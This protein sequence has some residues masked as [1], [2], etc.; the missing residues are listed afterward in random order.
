MQPPVLHVPGFCPDPNSVFEELLVYPWKQ[1][2]ITMFGKTHNEPRKVMWFA[3]KGLTYFYA[4][5]ENE[6]LEMTQLLKDIGEYA[7]AVIK[8]QM[9]RDVEFNSVF[10]NF[11]KDGDNYIGW[12][13]DDEPGIASD[14][15]A[16]VS[17]GATRDFQVRRTSDK[18]TWTFPLA[19]GDL[20]IMHSDCQENYK[21]CVPKRKKVKDPRINLTF[22][23]YAH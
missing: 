23:V 14:L 22:R 17:L 3:P 12:H 19:N 21:H 10:C 6:P 1:E 9:D 15:I 2:Q 20:A 11:Y 7:A 4:G 5:K 16:S 8:E 13:A 18:K